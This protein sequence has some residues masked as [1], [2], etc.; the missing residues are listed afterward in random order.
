MP[1]K[2]APL[3]QQ[4]LP[5]GAPP[6]CSCAPQRPALLATTVQQK[7]VIPS[8]QDGRGRRRQ[9]RLPEHACDGTA[10]GVAR[11]RGCGGP[12]SCGRFAGWQWGEQDLG[13]PWPHL[14]AARDGTRSMAGA[15]RR[16]WLG[17]GGAWQGCYRKPELARG[18]APSRPLHCVARIMAEMRSTW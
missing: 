17:C 15:R 12:S 3:Y 6:W 16:E 4:Q 5:S 7:W 1:S 13:V 14:A 11:V 2:I 8:A 18:A 10:A 9:E